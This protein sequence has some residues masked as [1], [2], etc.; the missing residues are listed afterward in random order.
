MDKI[1]VAE[2]LSA[3]ASNDQCRPMAARL[4]DVVDHVEAALAAGVPRARVLAELKALGLNMSLA[5]F[6]TT[7]RRIRARSRRAAH[8]ASSPNSPARSSASMAEPTPES[9]LSSNGTHRPA[10]LDQIMGSSPDLA[11]LAKFAKRR[12]QQ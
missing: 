7:L 2:R 4:R 12:K 1:L 5:T 11:A 8:T 9:V 10:D 3:L 6:E